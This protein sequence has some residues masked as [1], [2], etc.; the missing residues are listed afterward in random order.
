MDDRIN[1]LALALM[2]VGVTGLF[3]V[4]LFSVLG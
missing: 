1:L 3:G 2:I 4:L